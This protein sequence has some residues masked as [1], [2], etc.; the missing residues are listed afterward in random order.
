MTNPI[1]IRELKT[2][3]RKNSSFGSLVVLG[4]S[5]T[6]IMS[7]AW[8]ALTQSGNSFGEFNIVSRSLFVGISYLIFF[9]S[10][11]IVVTTTSASISTEREN[12][13]FD[14]LVATGLTKTHILLGKLISS[15]GF[16]FFLIFATLPIISMC[17]LMGGV[18]FREVFTAYIAIFTTL[19]AVGMMGIMCSAFC[20]TSKR[21][22]SLAGLL[23]IF[24]YMV[25]PIGTQIFKELFD[26]TGG[27]IGDLTVSLNPYFNFVLIFF[28]SSASPF[29]GLAWPLQAYP[30]ALIIISNCSLFALSYVL[31]SKFFITPEK[32]KTKVRKKYID[33]V[34]LLKQRRRRFP[35]YLIDPLK[36]NR[37]IRDNENPAYVKE[38]RYTFSTRMAFIIRFCYISLII[39]CL[40]S[41]PMF[42]GELSGGLIM[43][44]IAAMIMSSI[45][46]LNLASGSIVEE[47]ERDT[48]DLLRST[49]LKP[50]KVFFA[51]ALFICKT[52]FIIL[53][54]FTIPGII[55]TIFAW[56]NT[57]SDEQILLWYIS[58]SSMIMTVLLSCAVGLFFS[59]FKTSRRNAQAGSIAGFVLLCFS[60]L[61][62]AALGMAFCYYFNVGFNEDF[63]GDFSH[64]LAPFLSP[65]HYFIRA[66]EQAD[67][68]KDAVRLYLLLSLIFFFVGISIIYRL[69]YRR[70][71]NIWYHGH[72]TIP[73]LKS[74]FRFIGIKQ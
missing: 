29:R 44:T 74:V 45:F 33:N 3:L 62:I 40:L 18:S 22:M 71:R 13:T 53:A 43:F 5:A 38:K 8:F 73:I 35:Y 14:L 52:A 69:L 7:T 64:Y 49:L 70:F 57:S 47:F 1:V 4:V 60:P 31:A 12:Q 2:A 72:R 32:M 61:L 59:S 50:N 6:G 63:W 56:G 20:K 17:F 10:T 19:G 11:L 9:L 30:L 27:F 51:K 54:I 58:I 26:I 21:S 65:F 66:M 28:G 25:A 23:L 34:A 24:L 67:R 42:S 39:S 15:L 46:T 55:A 37:D 41:L 68:G 48:F 36:K 16:I